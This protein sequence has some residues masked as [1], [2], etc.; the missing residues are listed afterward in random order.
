[1]VHYKNC[2]PYFDLTTSEQY[3]PGTTKDQK[4]HLRRKASKYSAIEGKLVKQCENQ[5]L[6]VIEKAEVEEILKE[7]HDNS[8]HQNA[9]YTYNIGKDR[10]NLPRMVKDIDVYVKTCERCIRNQPSLKSPTSPIQ[11]LP[12]IT[13]VWFR[14]GMNLTSPLIESNGFKYILSVID[15]FTR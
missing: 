11:P 15:H 6:I 13:K 9:R 3:P 5:N 7:I 4:R 12:V 1:M 14:V 2:P 10:Y 8:G